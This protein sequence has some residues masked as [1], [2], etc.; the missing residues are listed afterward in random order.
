MLKGA[1]GHSEVRG[2]V[3]CEDEVYVAALWGG[4]MG[5]LR[6]PLKGMRPGK[7]EIYFSMGPD[8]PKKDG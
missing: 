1:E 7:I 3:E 5:I 8:K 6:H 2:P 4:T